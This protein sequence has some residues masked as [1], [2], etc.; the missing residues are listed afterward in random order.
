MEVIETFGEVVDKLSSQKPDQARKLL[1]TGW[2]FEKI[3]CSMVPE[4][5]LKKADRYLTR[6]MMDT[7]L[8]PL[9]HPETSAIVSIF[10]PCELLQEAGLH[11][12]NVEGFSSY[13]SGSCAEREFLQQAENTGISETLC[14]Y[15]KTFIGAAKEGV[16]PKPKCIVYTNLA[17][18]ANLLTFRYLSDLYQVPTFAIDVPLKQNDANVAYVAEQLKD[19][20]NF[21]ETVTGKTLEE[22]ALMQRV[23]RSKRTLGKYD[24]SQRARQD[25]YIPTDLKTP[26]FGGVTNNLLL[27]TKEQ[28]HYMDLLLKDIESAAP[29]T[30]I[31]LYWMHTIPFW[32]ESA[33]R[34]LAFNPEAQIVGE[35]LAAAYDTDFDPKE[36]Y[37][38]MAHRLVYHALNGSVNRRI[39]NGIDRAKEVHAD[40]AVWFAHWGCKHTLGAAQLAKKKFEDA[41]I[42]MLILD[43]DGCDRSHG[44]EGQTATRLGAFLEMLKGDRL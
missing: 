18:D 25:K 32:S 37:T 38:A 36:P 6:L 31:R 5:Q 21:L 9:E 40:G 13:L 28:E 16:L 10:T 11:P 17:C 30:G 4:K 12:Y 3:K 7:M 39:Q 34:E 1:R 15:H 19:L 42:P 8:Y 20:K 41:G 43:G 44:G 33:R 35:E 29:A 27:G 24:Q 22:D 2:A 23:A 14:S 26:M